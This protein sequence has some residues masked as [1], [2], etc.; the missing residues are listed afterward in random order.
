MLGQGRRGA[1]LHAALVLAG[2]RAG[3]V[4]VRAG[5]GLVVVGGRLV[6]GAQVVRGGR[7]RGHLRERLRVVRHHLQRP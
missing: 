2:R 7:V 6:V 5:A 4:A 3:L 1:R